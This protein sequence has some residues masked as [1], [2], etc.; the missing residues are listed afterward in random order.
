MGDKDVLSLFNGKGMEKWSWFP[1]FVK[2]EG[3]KGVFEIK[4]MVAGE[5]NR[6]T[7]VLAD[8][9]SCPGDRIY[10]YLPAD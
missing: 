8:N 1:P 7:W 2:V 4:Q 5:Q 3:A 6:F 9:N 10:S